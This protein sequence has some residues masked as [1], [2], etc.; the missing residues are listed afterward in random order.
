MRNIKKVISEL[1]HDFS[2]ANSLGWRLFLRDLRGMYRNSILGY[3]WSLAPSLSTALIWIFLQ[4]QRVVSFGDTGVPYPVYVLT[5][6][7]LWMMF[8]ES[9]MTPITSTQMS[10][11]LLNKLNF[12][13]ESILYSGLYMTLFNSALKLCIIA[14]VFVVFQLVPT[15]NVL[16][17]LL[18][19]VVFLLFGFTIGIWLVPLSL[20]YRD[21]QKGIPIGL[22]LF[23][24][25]TPVIYAVPKQGL[26]AKFMAINPLVP[27]LETTRD[28]L[29][30][31][32]IEYLQSFVLVTTFMFLFLFLGLFLYKLAM[33]IV[34]ERLGAGK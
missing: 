19:M 7:M 1:I 18:G 17:G 13:R 8:Q 14:L 11:M 26:I 32:P 6:M 34:I 22:R 24:Y 4:G 30:N 3:F 33:P 10:Q 15:W 21:V 16:L 2:Q 12:P 31:T 20:L 25:L 27:V 9:I 23:M 29:L 5:S 28:W